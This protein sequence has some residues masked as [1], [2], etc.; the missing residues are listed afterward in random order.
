MRS[1]LNS[2]TFKA[3][4]VGLLLLFFAA[5]PLFAQNTVKGTVSDESGRPL[6]GVTVMVKGTK[7]GTSTASDGSYSLGGVRKDAVLIFQCLGMAD[8]SVPVNGKL[9]INASLKEDTTFLC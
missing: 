8:Y 9:I 7:N 2:F 3:S 6:A 4:C 1:F 5:A